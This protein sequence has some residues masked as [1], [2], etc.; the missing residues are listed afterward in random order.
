[1]KEYKKLN[2][3]GNNLWDIIN[4]LVTLKMND[5]TQIKS[6]TVSGINQDGT[7]NIIIP[8][9]HTV[10][11]NVQNQSIYQLHVGDNVKILKEANNLSNIWI[12]GG[13][14]LKEQRY[15]TIINDLQQTIINLQ[16][17]IDKLK[18]RVGQLENQNIN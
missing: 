13:F 10:Y 1:M 11:H 5:L 9:N 18:Q 6:A 2:S 7:V 14:N 8:P 12:I 4:T 16:Q 3:I 17:E 15:D